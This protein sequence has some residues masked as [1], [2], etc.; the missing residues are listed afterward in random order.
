VFR[1]QKQNQNYALL[2]ILLIICQTVLAMDISEAKKMSVAEMESLIRANDIPNLCEGERCF[3][4]AISR[5]KFQE[6]LAQKK[7]AEAPRD[8]A[9][10]SPLTSPTVTLPPHELPNSSVIV[11]PVAPFGGDLTPE[12]K[13][14]NS[15]FFAELTEVKTLGAKDSLGDA[16]EFILAALALTKKMPLDQI[17]QLVATDA[18]D[19]RPGDT[20][21]QYL[22]L[23]RLS[24]EKLKFVAEQSGLPDDA[25]INL[26]SSTHEPRMLAMLNLILGKRRQAT[27]VAE[28]S[29][30]WR[31]LGKN[32]GLARATSERE[33]SAHGDLDS[34]SLSQAGVLNSL[35]HHGDQLELL[36]G[37]I[38]KR[39]SNVDLPKDDR[40]YLQYLLLGALRTKSPARP[41][42]WNQSG[43]LGM[44]RRQGENYLGGF[45]KN[46]QKY[47]AEAA[48]WRKKVEQNVHLADGNLVLSTN[49]E[50]I[51][52]I[53]AGFTPDSVMHYALNLYRK[54]DEKSVRLAEKIWHLYI[55]NEFTI[56]LS[57]R[58]TPVK[59]EPTLK[60]YGELLRSLD[61][62]GDRLTIE[63]T[64][65][66]I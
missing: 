15:D 39:L 59:I 40:K 27:G 6:I 54:N 47:G 32:E 4:P 26:I 65:Y 57:D 49:A 45:E 35:R 60:N 3:A 50:E 11:R 21:S 44:D 64:G 2:F 46:L 8:V 20:V 5:Q 52:K 31:T 33:F 53:R 12:Q 19:A 16:P 13:L 66:D 51:K 10:P 22:S 37:Q 29:T 48:G 1:K 56:K 7:V 36:I 34:L 58:P 18:M 63:R 30:Y 28:I 38:Q 55:G 17:R 61:P 43:L 42:D 14:K 41:L 25:L 9:R 62:F 24:L 23:N